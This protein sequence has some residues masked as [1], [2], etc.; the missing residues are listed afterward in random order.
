M[1]KKESR[2]LVFLTYIIGLLTFTIIVLFYV[3][4][5]KQSLLDDMTYSID[6]VYPVV[7]THCVNGAWFIKSKSHKDRLFRI[8]NLTCTGK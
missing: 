5:Q 2:G 4:G 1:T 3:L 8:K 6:A 7:S